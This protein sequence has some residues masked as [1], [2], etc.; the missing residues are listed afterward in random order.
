MD[1]VLCILDADTL[2]TNTPRKTYGLALAILQV[3]RLP[4]SILSPF[5][6]RISSA[7]RRGLDGEYGREGKKGPTW[8]SLGV[9]PVCY[10]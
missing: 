7:I 10:W 3:Q 4:E 6:E 8:E 2:P 5:T 1:T 9:R